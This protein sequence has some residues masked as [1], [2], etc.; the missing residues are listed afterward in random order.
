M[1]VADK[2]I[3]G[4]V[5]MPSIVVLSNVPDTPLIPPAIPAI[6]IMPVKRSVQ[7]LA[8]IAGVMSIAA[9]KITPTV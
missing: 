1:I 2:I 5:A 8:A 7:Y 6:M 3:K 9:I 4:P